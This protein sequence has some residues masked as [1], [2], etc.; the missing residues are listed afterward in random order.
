MGRKTE[1]RDRTE[2]NGSPAGKST[3]GATAGG[4]ASEE[5]HSGRYLLL[6]LP[7]LCDDPMRGGEGPSSRHTQQGGKTEKPAWAGASQQM[8]PAA[9]P[10]RRR[11][12]APP[13]RRAAHTGSGSGSPLSAILVRS[14]LKEEELGRRCRPTTRF[15]SLA[16]GRGEARSQAAIL[17]APQ[18]WKPLFGL[19]SYS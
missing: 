18:E 7:V 6:D 14:A 11:H 9:D 16:L 17:A 1:G 19:F 2:A 8:E 10:Y 12:L 13:T 4:R 3:P 15:L 5:R